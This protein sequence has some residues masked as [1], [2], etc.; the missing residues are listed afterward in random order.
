MSIC[1]TAAP[2]FVP[3]WALL[4]VSH[5]RW[6][7]RSAGGCVSAAVTVAC[8]AALPPLAAIFLLSSSSASRIARRCAATASCSRRVA[9]SAMA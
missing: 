5:S 9:L 4:R 1:A 6:A 8:F 3:R 2:V 7:K